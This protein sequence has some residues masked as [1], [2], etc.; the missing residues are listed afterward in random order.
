MRFF[1]LSDTTNP[2]S[3][4]QVYCFKVVWF[5]STSSPFMLNATLHHHL[6]QFESPVAVD[7]LTNLY[8]DNVISGCN[9]HDQAIWYYQMARSIMSEANFNLRAW[10]SNCPQLNT[11]A[12]QD[13]VADENTTTSILGLQWNTITDTLCFPSKTI[14]PENSTLI[15]KREVLQQSSKIFD[16]LG[17]L[18]PVTIQAKLFMQSLWQKRIDCGEPLD[19]D[20]QD[21]W[22]TIARDILDATTM[23]IP[24]RYF[25]NEDLSP[26][27]QLHV[28]LT[29][30]SRPTVQ[31]PIS[32]S[33]TTQPL[34]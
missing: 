17:F 27:T 1:W 7:M 2:N 16:P 21:E 24:R 11:L 8:V 23:V 19:K 14:I 15:T 32:K 18:S 10:A 30:A 29:P 12:K 3:E 33:I 25:T 6:Q 13:K 31:S 22:L 4:L 5:G 28:S 9:S 20:L 34:S 26:T